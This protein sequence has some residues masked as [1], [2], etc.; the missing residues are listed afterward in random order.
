MKEKVEIEEGRKRSI[1]EREGG[2]ME[3]II[4]IIQHHVDIG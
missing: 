2:G 1:R 3:N 4:K